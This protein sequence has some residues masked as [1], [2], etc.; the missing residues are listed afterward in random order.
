MFYFVSFPS[1]FSFPFLSELT[2]FARVV[3]QPA[4]TGYSYVTKNDNVRELA[5]SAEQVVNF[6]QNLYKIFPEY[7]TMDVSQ[8]LLCQLR[9]CFN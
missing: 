4:G 8:L 3:D 2:A 6:L 1:Q 7:S 9:Q 5:E